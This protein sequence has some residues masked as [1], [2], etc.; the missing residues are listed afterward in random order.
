MF[1]RYS[2]ELLPNQ[3]DISR[4]KLLVCGAAGVGKTELI[5][6]LK[7]PFLRSL[8][9]RRS[10]SNLSHML[11]QRT[12][13]ISV[14]QETIPSAGSFSIWDFSGVK[15]Y[16]LLHEEFL[17]VTN[18]VILLVVKACE[19]VEDQV[20]QLRFWL[21]LIKAKRLHSER[22]WFAGGYETKPNVAIVS[23]FASVPDEIDSEQHDRR[24]SLSPSAASHHHDCFIDPTEKEQVL[25]TVRKEFS[26]YFTFS[27]RIFQLDCRLS[28]SNEIKALRQ[29]LGAVRCQVIQVCLL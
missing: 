18:S 14:Q 24:T 10:D 8:F 12:H 7:C 26:N 11:Q 13:G 16:Y 6:S 25:E 29:H 22:V 15:N 2:T 23:S 5:K 28:Q 19:P 17:R 27:E 3:I 4:V 1:D 9:R 20:T 21:S